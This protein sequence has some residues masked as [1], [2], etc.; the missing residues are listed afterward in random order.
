VRAERVP[1]REGADDV[2]RASDHCHSPTVG[3]IRSST[4]HPAGP[5][6]SSL[7]GI[8]RENPERAELESRAQRRP[9][10]AIFVDRPLE[11]RETLT[12]RGR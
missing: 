5:N 12:K 7:G 11:Q 10:R 1:L 2:S 3:R 6:E 8:G 4:L 9:P